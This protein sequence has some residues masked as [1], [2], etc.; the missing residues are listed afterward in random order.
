[1]VKSIH[2]VWEERGGPQAYLGI[3]LD[4]FPNFFMIFGPNTATGHSSVILASE[5][6]V[7]Y[8][9]RFVKSIL[10]GTVSTWEVKEEAERK[11]TSRIQKDLKETTFQSGGCVSWYSDDQGWNS[12]I[13]P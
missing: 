7:N 6:S 2:D 1:M 10:D 12:V 9:L 11:W 4:K 13:Y 8:T 5:N 3:A